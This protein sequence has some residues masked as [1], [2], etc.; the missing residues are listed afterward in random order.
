MRVCD[1]VCIVLIQHLLC[2]FSIVLDKDGFIY[3]LSVGKELFLTM[4]RKKAVDI[5]W[6]VLETIFQMEY[7]SILT[8]FVNLSSEKV[9]G[10]CPFNSFCCLVQC[11]LRTKNTFISHKLLLALQNNKWDHYF[12]DKTVKTQVWQ[13][14]YE[15]LANQLIISGYLEE[16]LQLLVR[17]GE[18]K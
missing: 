10:R 12:W 11:C 17:V 8:V 13:H 3:L 2:L 7:E 15:D 14:C 16:C 4:W 18:S 6:H 5:A 9:V 1:I